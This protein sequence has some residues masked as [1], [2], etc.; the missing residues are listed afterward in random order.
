MQTRRQCPKCK[1]WS[2]FDEPM[3]FF[4]TANLLTGYCDDCLY[5]RFKELQLVKVKIVSP[6]EFDEG[7]G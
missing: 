1:K 5:L 4:L 6:L 7:Q 3:P 2:R